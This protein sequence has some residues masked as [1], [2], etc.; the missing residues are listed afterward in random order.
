MEAVVAPAG[1]QIAK[2]GAEK[3]D[4]AFGRVRLLHVLLRS[5]ALHPPRAVQ[6][7]SRPARAHVWQV[8]QVHILG[9]GLQ[10]HCVRLGAVDLSAIAVAKQQRAS[11]VDA[12]G[13]TE[14]TQKKEMPIGRSSF[15]LRTRADE[16]GSLRRR[17][18]RRRRR[19]AAHHST[20]ICRSVVW[21]TDHMSV[22][23]K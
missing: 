16:C 19:R 10:I 18:R 17:R 4:D 11:A 6:H 3:V 22:S 12:R 20:W 1:H 14:L 5:H 7:K 2:D 21:G 9:Q 15:S 8:L 23:T 13:G